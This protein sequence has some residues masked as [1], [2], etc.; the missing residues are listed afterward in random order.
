M[1]KFILFLFG[2]LPLMSFSQKAAIWKGNSPGHALDWHWPANWSSN[3][4]PDE[5]TDVIIPL[6]NSTSFNYPQIQKGDVEINSLYIS[7]GA[8]L[9]LNQ[10]E[11]VILDVRKSYFKSSQIIRKIKSND[12]KEFISLQ[13]LNASN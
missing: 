5:F 2:L 7:P 12:V 3:S 8:M 6:D 13:P 10:F 11:I 1:K 4:M 9:L